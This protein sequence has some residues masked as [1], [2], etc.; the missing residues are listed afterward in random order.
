MDKLSAPSLQALVRDNLQKRNAFQGQNQ[1]YEE[2]KKKCKDAKMVVNHRWSTCW[3]R[4]G[5]G[6]K[7][8][9]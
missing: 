7:E 9:K 5:F 8:A 1:L 4:L 2:T 3:I 6:V